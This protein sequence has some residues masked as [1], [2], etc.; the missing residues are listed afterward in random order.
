MPESNAGE[1]AKKLVK[2][3]DEMAASLPTGTL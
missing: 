3:D 2:A 1:Y